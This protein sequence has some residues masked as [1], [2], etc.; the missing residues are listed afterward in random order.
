MKRDMDLIR[1]ILLQMESS[2]NT[3]DWAKINI[4]DVSKETISYHI[5]LLYQAGLIEALDASDSANFEWIAKSITWEGHEFLEAA[6]T[7]SNW[8][9]AKKIITSKGVSLSFEALKI[10]L[11]FLMKEQLKTP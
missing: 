8:Q 7:N 5:K 9:K 1:E 3:D 2:N 4:A 10:A 11:S 6:R